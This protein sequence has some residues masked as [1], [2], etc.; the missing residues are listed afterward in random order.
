[1]RGIQR[2]QRGKTVAPGG[3]VAQRTGVGRLVGIEHFELRTDGAGVGERQADDKPQT[4]GG[5]IERENLQRIVQLGDDDA[6]LVITP[7]VVALRK[8]ALDAV[9][10]QARQPQAED[11]PTVSRKGTHHISIP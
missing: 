2:H 7:P 1:M 8:L 9:D 4:C 10:G 6:G 5:I 11:A 3:D